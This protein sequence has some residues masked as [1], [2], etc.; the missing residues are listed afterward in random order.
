MIFQRVHVQSLRLLA[1][2][3]AGLNEKTAVCEL[4]FEYAPAINWDQSEAEL[5]R[6]LHAFAPLDRLT[7]VEPP[8]WP[9]CFLLNDVPH[10][11]TAQQEDTMTSHLGAWAVALTTA[12]QQWARDPVWHGRV[13]EAH[14]ARVRVA[15]PWQREPVVKA[16][17]VWA[18]RLLDAWSATGVKAVAKREALEKEVRDWLAQTQQGGLVPNSLRFAKAAAERGMPCTLMPGFIQ[19]GW[20]SEAQRFDSSFTGRTSNLAARL[21]RNKWLA[22]QL[23]AKAGLPVPACMP[24]GAIEQA[25][26][27]AQQLGW[28]VVVK[29][30]N[31]DQGT[32]VVPGI[33]D[34]ATLQTAFEKAAHY[35]PGAVLVEKHIEGEDY[36]LLVVEG[37]LLMATHRAP[38]G[39]LGDD[40]HTVTQLVA[41]VNADPRRARASAVC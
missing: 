26:Q 9:G 21:A 11:P 17:L 18:L 1:G 24:V 8:Q 36:R 32:A 29:P 5:R 28:P 39:V 20:G 22:S 10:R 33:R 41:Q 30:S 34:E 12:L 4:Q 14:K 40:T 35:S 23:L 13:L 16:A 38:G 31:Q 25:L 19:L 37:A 6:H 2:C 15:L 27:A 7:P 3:S